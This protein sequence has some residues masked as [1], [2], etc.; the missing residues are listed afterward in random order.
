MIA[1]GI[2]AY[3]EKNAVGIYRQYCVLNLIHIWFKQIILHTK[4]LNTIYYLF[5]YKWKIWRKFVYEL[6]KF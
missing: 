3:K 1:H 2:I 5:N 4:Y 6:P